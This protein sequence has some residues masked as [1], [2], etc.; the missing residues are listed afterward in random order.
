MIRSAN[1][2]FILNLFSQGNVGHL[3]RNQEHLG[4]KGTFAPE[5][6]KL[7]DI[8]LPVPKNVFTRLFY[9]FLTLKHCMS[10][11]AGLFTCF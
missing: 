3:L 10:E 11:K 2:S 1:K 8:L 7:A 4:Y 9:A 6:V 5:I